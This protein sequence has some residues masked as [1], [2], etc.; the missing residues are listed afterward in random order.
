MDCRPRQSRQGPLVTAFRL[1]RTRHS[2]ATLGC[3]P[4]LPS[5]C[6]SS[7]EIE[8]SSIALGRWAITAGAGSDDF[9]RLSGAQSAGTADQ[10]LDAVA[11]AE[12]AASASVAVREPPERRQQARAVEPQMTFRLGPDTPGAAPCHRGTGRRRPSRPPT[13]SAAPSMDIRP[14][15][16]RPGGSRCWSC[17]RGHRRAR[18]LGRRRQSSR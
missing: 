3:R 5:E 10:G 12:A 9:D 13:R 1:R 7:T 16:L 8:P 11:E 2:L 6:S 4:D 17:A 18:P 14:R 15:A